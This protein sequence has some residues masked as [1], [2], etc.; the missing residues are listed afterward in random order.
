MNQGNVGIRWQDGVSDYFLL[1]RDRPHTY[2]DERGGT[3]YQQWSEDSKGT[4][5]RIFKM[6]NGS[7]H[8]W[9]S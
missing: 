4:R 2:T 3:V 5:V 6:Q 9:G 1:S 7:I 8:I